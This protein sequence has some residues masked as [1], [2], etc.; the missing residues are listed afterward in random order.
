MRLFSFVC[1]D[2]Y[3]YDSGCNSGV[4]NAQNIGIFVQSKEN[5]RSN[6]L[7]KGQIAPLDAYGLKT[8]FDWKRHLPVPVIDWL[9]LK[10]LVPA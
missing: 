3:F 5:I 1:K 8:S 4:T 7:E 9:H 10:N 6:W 2:K